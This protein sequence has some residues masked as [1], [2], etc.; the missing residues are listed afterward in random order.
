MHGTSLLWPVNQSGKRSGGG[1]SLMVVTVFP[2]S[3][4]RS[5]VGIGMAPPFTESSS[6]A[7]VP[8]N[9]SE[10]AASCPA[11]SIH[12]AVASISFPGAS[13]ASSGACAAR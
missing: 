12:C 8:P 2:A 10:T 6:K 3:A 1:V 4:V 7:E 5:S 9:R 11:A 13:R